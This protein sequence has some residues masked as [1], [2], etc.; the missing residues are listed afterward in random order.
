LSVVVIHDC[1]Y[2]APVTRRHQEV[3]VRA[4]HIVI[5]GFALSALAGCSSD[6]EPK[7][8]VPAPAASAAPSTSSSMDS[9]TFDAAAAYLTAL[10]KIDQ[11]LAANRETALNDGQSICLE[12]QEKKTAAELEK[13]TAARF[14]VDP[15]QA[16]QILATAK[17]NLCLAQ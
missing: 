17:T 14:S 2:R 12:I 9:G 1:R 10:G 16:K 3:T 11:K 4:R 8:D 7:T 5:A 6:A 13:N 15:T